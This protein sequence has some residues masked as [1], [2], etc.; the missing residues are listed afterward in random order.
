MSTPPPDSP[1]KPPPRR[2]W[3]TS[4]IAAAVL[5]LAI[6]IF[7][8]LPGEP[9]VGPGILDNGK[10]GPH[11]ECY[12]QYIAHGWP[13]RFLKHLGPPSDPTNWGKPLS[14]WSIGVSPRVEWPKLVA[15]IMIV[16]VGS[17]LLGWLVQRHI[18][19]YGYRFGLGNLAML[20]L[21]IAC[22]LGYGTY[23]YRLQ[24][25]QLRAM[26][27]EDIHQSTTYREWEPF[28]PYWLRSITGDKLWS[29]GD[30]MIAVE[31]VNSPTI[32]S[33]PGKS[34]VK[35]IRLEEFNLDDPP[36]L[37]AYPNLVGLDA[38]FVH[39]TWASWT[40]ENRDVALTKFL[41]AVAACETIEGI[42]FYEL[43]MTDA[44]LKELS[45]M[46]NLKHLDISGNPEVTDAGLVHLASIKSLQ[47]LRLF[48]TKVTKQGVEKLQAELPECEIEWDGMQ[49]EPW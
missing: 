19:K 9:I 40:D 24:Q 42:N 38:W 4:A 49:R 20:L 29:W 23:R 1:D 6:G 11:F 22:V 21:V 15:N 25:A 27:T 35:V 43:E 47:V 31:Y 39:F 36:N 18:T 10:Y 14:P 46:P 17:L 8:N 34:S 12:P 30:R 41:Q 48:D 3:H 13:L 26:L 32:D 33:F 28:G 2:R 16:L 7:L 5:A 37:A 44:D 45:G